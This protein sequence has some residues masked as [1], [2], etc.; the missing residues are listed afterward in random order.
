MEDANFTETEESK[1]SKVKCE[2][3]AH[4]FFRFSRN[5]APRI[6][7]SWTD[8]QSGILL[9]AFEAIE[10]ECAKKTP[11]NLE[12]G[13][14]VSPSWQ[15]PSSNSFVCDPVFG[16]YGMDRR[17]PPTLFTGHSPLWFLFIADNKKTVKGKRFANVEEVKTASQEALNI[18]L[19]Q[20]QR[21]FTSSKRSRWAARSDVTRKQRWQRDEWPFPN[22]GTGSDV[23]RKQT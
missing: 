18:K 23:T 22:Q 13:W 10:R 4:C 12:I 19:H 1:T 8:C 21:C 7:S 16:L 11:R 2:N 17:S 14:L 15:R 9:G 5:R 3:Y 20:F 6:R